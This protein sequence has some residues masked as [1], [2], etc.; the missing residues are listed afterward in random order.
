MGWIEKAK[1]RQFLG[2]HGVHSS[3]P[4]EFVLHKVPCVA[5][6]HFIDFHLIGPIW[7]N[8]WFDVRGA[9]NYFFLLKFGPIPCYTVPV[10][11]YLPRHSLF[12]A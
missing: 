6:E 4:T 3:N 5:L 9:L 8:C 7:K 12:T 1:S 11:S 10:N 2:Y